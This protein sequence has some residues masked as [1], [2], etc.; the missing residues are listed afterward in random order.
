M[1]NLVIY[2]S[3]GLTSKSYFQDPDLSLCEIDLLYEQRR[4]GVCEGN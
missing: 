3:P 4:C 2:P 1:A